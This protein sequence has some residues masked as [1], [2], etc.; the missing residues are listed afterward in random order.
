MNN[1]KWKQN[2]QTLKTNEKKRNLFHC[3]AE[4][5]FKSLKQKF[6]SSS[7]AKVIFM[8]FL[9]RDMNQRIK[10]LYKQSVAL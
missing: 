9:Q 3:Y 2:T 4:S 1:T 8:E 10:Q 6:K 5:M 7:K